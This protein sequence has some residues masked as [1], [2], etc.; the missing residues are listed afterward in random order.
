MDIKK[1]DNFEE[2]PMI[3]ENQ[4][5]VD[6]IRSFVGMIQRNGIPSFEVQLQGF[7]GQILVDGD[8][9]FTTSGANTVSVIFAYVSG[10]FLGLRNCKK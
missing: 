9:R 2:E 3:T 1:I 8:V 4:D 5:D 10:T 6:N 7:Q